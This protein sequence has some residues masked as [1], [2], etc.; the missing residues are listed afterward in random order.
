[1]FMT[2]SFNRYFHALSDT[3]TLSVRK[4]ARLLVLDCP[5]A[6]AADSQLVEATFLSTETFALSATWTYLDRRK[7]EKYS[8]VGGL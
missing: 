7:C 6:A 8:A 4:L 1:M 3:L 2:M 5:F